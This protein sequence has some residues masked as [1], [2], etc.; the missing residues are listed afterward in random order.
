VDREFSLDQDFLGLCMEDLS[1]LER[2]FSKE[3]IRDVVR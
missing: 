1:D 3:E 2:E